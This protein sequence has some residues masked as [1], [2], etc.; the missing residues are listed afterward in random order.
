M[1]KISNKL[2]AMDTLS[3][4]AT[5]LL[6]SISCVNVTEPTNPV[7]PKTESLTVNIN[8][9]STGINYSPGDTIKLYASI[10]YP[11]YSQSELSICW[12]SNLDGNLKTESIKSTSG[13]E[14]PFLVVSNLT[15]GIHTITIEV[16]TQNGNTFSS[17]VIVNNLMS[18]MR[19]E[20]PNDSA[21]LTWNKFIGVFFSQYTIY[22][23]DDSSGKSPVVV[24]QSHDINDTT[25]TD[26]G[27][28]IG[29]TYNYRVVVSRIGEPDC[30]SGLKQIAPG[31]FI[32]F[33][34][35]ILKVIPDTKRNCIY[36]LA[37]TD[38]YISTPDNRYGLIKFN[39]KQR[40]IID[41]I[42]TDI[43]FSDLDIDS[44]GSNLFLGSQGEK[45][46]YQVSLETFK[47]VTKIPTEMAVNK[48]EA[49][50][51]G[52][53]YYLPPSSSWSNFHLVDINNKVEIHFKCTADV[54]GGD[55]EM[56]P[57]GKYLFYGASGTSGSNLYRLDV[58]TDTSF[59]FANIYRGNWGS[60]CLLLSS[61]GKQL[62]WTSIIFNPQCEFIGS[63]PLQEFALACN[64]TGELAIGNKHL[65]RVSD[66]NIIRTIS[67][68]YTNAIFS[69]EPNELILLNTT[70]STSGYHKS[71]IYFYPF[72][73]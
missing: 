57:S 11:Y 23:L 52:R 72:V 46:I 39:T 28:T 41:Q 64:P 34:K 44:S 65:F 43:I 17:N 29:V 18:I 69:P 9:P 42:L 30:G 36:L 73:D 70:S 35:P 49:G 60:N 20:A 55:I 63:F 59:E 68:L 25:F 62:F 27:L 33:D 12:K 56:D 40:K 31:T 13:N 21:F 16:R 32:E 66:Q 53:V 37:S 8:S 48:I 10:S 58:S 1:K 26:T 3:G 15:K 61:N 67:C 51:P 54:Y 71:R 5:T 2:F 6:V 45:N 50:R 38:S 19:A 22:R 4:I 47:L 24:H 7:L 14:S